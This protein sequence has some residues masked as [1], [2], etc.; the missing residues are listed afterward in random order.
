MVIEIVLSVRFVHVGDDRGEIVARA[1]E[2]PKIVSVA[3]R[4]IVVVPNVRTP[5]ASICAGPRCASSSSK[6]DMWVCAAATQS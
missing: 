1:L 5:S 3:S 2:E 4:S 6:R